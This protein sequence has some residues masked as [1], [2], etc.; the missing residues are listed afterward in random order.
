MADNFDSNLEDEKERL[1]IQKGIRESLKDQVNT[2]GDMASYGADILRNYKEIRSINKDIAK[3][4]KT[5]NQLLEQAKTASK[6]EAELLKKR[7]AAIAQENEELKKQA[8]QLKAINKQMA[9]TGNFL[10]GLFNV[11]LNYAKQSITAYLDFD[12][13][14]R[15]VAAS[16]GLSNDRMYQMRREIDGAR[17]MMI[18]YGYSVEDAITAQ[19]TYSGE[20]GRAVILSESALENMSK[21]AKA[22]G[23]GMEEMAGMSSE[24][25]NFG[26]GAEDSS[27]F[28]YDMYAE[29]SKMGLNAANVSK[30][31][32]QNLTLLNKLNFK[33]GV[34]G[35]K[36][37]TM[38]SEK[39][40]ID[41]QSVAA[42]AEHLNSIENS[43]E[44]AANL[45]VLGGQFAAMADPIQLFYK[46][47]NAPE[48][49][50]KS[51]AE[52][53]GAAAN[54]NK[55][56]GEV[57]L[58]AVEMDR[59]RLTAKA[60]NL[61]FENLVESAK[62][63]RLNKEFSQLLNGKGL[64]AKTQEAVSM[65][66]EMKDGKAQINFID[67]NGMRVVK[68]LKS[69]T[70]TEAQNLIQQKE[71]AQKAAEQATGVKQQYEA[72]FNNMI[73]TLWPLF[74]RLMPRFKDIADRIAA[75]ATKFFDGTQ[76]FLE[77]FGKD[78][79]IEGFLNTVADVGRNL[80]T[81]IKEIANSPLVKAITSF[82]SNNAG[83][84]L[85]IGL[86]VKYL[87]PMLSPISWYLKGIQLGA[88]FNASQRAGGGGI[89]STLFGG[90]GKGGGVAPPVPPTPPMGGGAQVAGQASG[91]GSMMSSLGSAAQILAVGAALMMLAKSVEILANAALIIKNNDLGGTMVGLLVGI[92]AFVALMGALGTTGIGEAA[93]LVIIGIGLGMLMIGGAVW[94]VAQGM[95]S[96]VDAFTRMF[97]ILPTAGTQLLDA[98]LGFMSMAAGIGILTAS[99]I[100]LSAA[101]FIALPGMLMLGAV[102]GML[103]GTASALSS[104]GGGDGL[105]RAVEAINSVDVSKLDALKS[106]SMWM[107]LLGSDLKVSFDEN[108]TVQG[109]IELVGE[110][111]KATV[112]MNNPEHIKALKDAIFRSAD[113]QKQGKSVGQ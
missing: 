96:V 67:K 22:T 49:L 24:M 55:Q 56:T 66:A 62:R 113:N 71:D 68:D 46:A 85:G 90:K 72:L 29:S 97:T 25:A 76:N 26:Y 19:S 111:G 80:I 48:E 30:K 74:E 57:T 86:L 92:S 42:A 15:D 12:Q 103:I 58:N 61:D 100:A 16:I 6:E 65:M 82:V 104:V 109:S 35:L 107:A 34:K 1:K 21:V 32:R 112:D 98:G 18:S 94:L 83:W 110:K 43:I 79:D 37:M 53:A 91:M 108:L 40:K 20:L 50:T 13:K 36:N 51:F 77:N 102:T 3:N 54:F 88:G 38:L 31:F 28:I 14:T 10:R 84:L 93:I 63:V 81:A 45:Q 78:W 75:W 60:L 11:S 89:L 47:R 44:A 99:L 70:K 41:M 4:Q 33:D 27:K 39:F 59:L 23:M 9:S 101:S 2:I 87:G 7:A 8:A 64:D 5:I 52:A 17:A 106:L 73:T 105:T 95:T 69:L